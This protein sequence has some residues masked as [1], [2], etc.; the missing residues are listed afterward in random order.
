[1]HKD[2]VVGIRSVQ[3]IEASENR[4]GTTRTTNAGRQQGMTGY[5]KCR[6]ILVVWRE[7]D[8][9]LLQFGIVEQRLQGVLDD[10]PPPELQILLG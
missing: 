6:E 4:I 1:M 3:R 9:Q 2:P 8:D 7:H 5:A 10:R